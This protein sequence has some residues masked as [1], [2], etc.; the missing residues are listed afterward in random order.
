MVTKFFPWRTV[1]DKF[2]FIT[3]IQFPFRINIIITLLFS[4]V[5]GYSIC[6]LINNKEELNYLIY[7]ALVLS[8]LNLLSQVNIN[9]KNFTENDI[10]NYSPLGNAE[11]E[12]YGLNLDDADVHNVNSDE[13][14]EFTRYG[15]KIEFNY[16]DTENEMTIHIPFTYYKGYKAYIEDENG[17]KTKLDVLE[18][19]NTKNVLICSN[20]IKTG[21]ITVEYKMTAVQIIAYT[22]TTVTFI[23][24]IVYIFYSYYKLYS[25][26]YLAKAL[27][28][29]SKII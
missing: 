13:K 9:S 16:L 28:T 10:L 12:P 21:K 6:N 3:I 23:T 25:N 11:Y 7:I 29:S 5:G 19:E 17:I 18:D 24:L 26:K 15:S 8:T 20:E 4:F 1:C 2:H 22:I 14:I 27:S